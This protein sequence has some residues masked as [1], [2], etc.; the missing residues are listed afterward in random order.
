[1]DIGIA[2]HVVAALAPLANADKAAPMRV[3]EKTISRFRESPRRRGRLSGLPQREASK[4]PGPLFCKP[5]VSLKQ[6]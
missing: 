2:E 5:R 4:H 1:V 6:E 3:H